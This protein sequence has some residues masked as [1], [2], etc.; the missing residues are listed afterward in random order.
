MSIHFTAD[1]CCVWLHPDGDSASGCRHIDQDSSSTGVDS[2]AEALHQELK[3]TFLHTD[4][5]G[6]TVHLCQGMKRKC[7]CNS[8]RITDIKIL[9]NIG[10]L[11]LLTQ[12]LQLNSCNSKVRNITN[13]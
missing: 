10:T 11:R 1:I 7:I 4:S 8:L 6:Y 9:K 12:V 3:S 2:Q 13:F 5:K